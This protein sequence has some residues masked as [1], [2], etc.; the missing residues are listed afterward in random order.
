MEVDSFSANLRMEAAYVKELLSVPWVC[1]AGMVEN[2]ELLVDQY[3]H[4]RGLLEATVSSAE[5][6]DEDSVAAAQSLLDT[7]RENMEQ[8]GGRLEDQ[9]LIQLVKEK[10]TSKPCSNQGFV[11]DGFPKTYMQARELFSD[12]IFSLDASDDFLKERVVN[13]PESAVEGT[14]YRQDIFLRRLASYRENNREDET[15]LNYFDEL[16]VVPQHIE[17]TDGK[18]NDYL[19]ATEQIVQ[20]VGPPQELRPQ[21]P[22]GGEE[23]RKRVEEEIQR[24]PGTGPGGTP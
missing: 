18:D 13:L 1:E 10:L 19:L 6:E 15:V 14:S 9:H 21:Q 8:N 12:F 4:T 16:D 24:R 3:K 7:L 5:P 11:L 23:D 17:I 20:A 2:V 22:R